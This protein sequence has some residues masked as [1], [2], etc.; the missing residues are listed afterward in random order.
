MDWIG[1]TFGLGQLH[2]IEPTSSAPPNNDPNATW[3]VPISYHHAFDDFRRQAIS[4]R[5]ALNGVGQRVGTLLSDGQIDKLSSNDFAWINCLDVFLWW[6]DHAIAGPAVAAKVLSGIT[7]IDRIARAMKGATVRRILVSHSLGTAVATDAVRTL[8]SSS[9]FTA[10]GG[11]DLWITLANVAPFLVEERDVYAPPL[12]PRSTGTAAK[13]FLNVRNEADPIPW[14]LPWRAWNPDNAG[15]SIA[16]W[17]SS[18]RFN[19]V[20]SVST[21]GVCAP[22]NRQPEITNVHGFANYLLAPGFAEILAGA[23]RAE[24]FSPQE[25]AARQW[26]SAWNELPRLSCFQDSKALDKLATEVSVFRA[27]QAPSPDRPARGWFDRL[28]SAAD[29]LAKW[30]GLC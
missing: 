27:L 3:L 22:P 8:S 18:R 24:G 21:R 19:R 9:E 4:R 6:A 2:W 11:F 5:D 26:P 25:L 14:L 7:N 12:I 1:T 30:K 10:M 28:L 20:L 15:A 17:Q 29:M 16:D 13:V 23:I